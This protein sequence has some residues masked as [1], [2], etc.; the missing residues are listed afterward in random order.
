MEIKRI[1]QNIKR[2][3]LVLRSR[4]ARTQREVKTL[5]PI[6]EPLTATSS[7]INNPVSMKHEG[8][9]EVKNDN[10]QRL[11]Y[12]IKQTEIKLQNT[13]EKIEGRN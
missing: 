10:T 7:T 2:E 3:H 11:F 12:F 13:C 1:Q 9:R 4:I 8:K 5:E 6:I